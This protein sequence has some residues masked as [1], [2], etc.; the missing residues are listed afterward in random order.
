[1]KRR[2][3]ESWFVLKL[4]GAQLAS[5]FEPLPDS[6]EDALGIMKSLP[7]TRCVVQLEKQGQVMQSK[8]SLE[9]LLFLLIRRK[10]WLFAASSFQYRYSGRVNISV[11]YASGSI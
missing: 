6:D 4:Q 10:D 8:P 7:P 5:L 9:T 2:N 11:L 1:M 3:C